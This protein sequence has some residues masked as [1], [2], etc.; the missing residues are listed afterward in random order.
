MY[1]SFMNNQVPALWSN[2]SFASLKTLAS[3]NKDL[4]F[5]VAFMRKWLQ[6][7]QPACFP[8]P[9]FFFPQGF[10]TGTLQ[11]YARKYQ[12]A[13]D[14]LNYRFN[15]MTEDPS[16]IKEAPEDGIYCHGL[17]LEGARWDRDDWRLR[18][19]RSGE[20][21]MLLPLIHFIPAVGHKTASTDYACPV[22]K[23]AE[24]KG[25]LSTTG[26]STNFVIAV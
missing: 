14:T 24:R 23:T 11:T 26:M 7:G 19:S 2:V 25:V 5:R 13:I 22:Y 10:M 1:T 12:V 20:M 17:W 15:V 8:L 16:D 3:W 18:E 6:E 21:Y 9:V 4:I